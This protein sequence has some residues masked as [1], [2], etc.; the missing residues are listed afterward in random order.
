MKETKEEKATGADYVELLPEEIVI[1]EEINVRPWSTAHESEADQAAIE[2]LKTSIAQE[3]QLQAIRVREVAS[4]GDKP[5]YHLIAGR[6]R[7]NAIF[8]LNAELSAKNK[9]GIR[10]KAIVARDVDDPAAYRQAAMENIIRRDMSPMDIA[11]VIKTVREN[12][13]WEGGKN[14]KSVAKYLGVSPATISQHEKLLTLP[15]EIQAKVHAGELSAQA[16][17]DYKE[18]ADKHGKEAADEVLAD[19]KARQEAE[20]AGKVTETAQGAKG[21]EANVSSGGEEGEIAPTGQGTRKKGKV[22]RAGKT[23]TAIKARHVQSAARQKGLGM[24]PLGKSDIVEF[25]EKKVAA[26]PEVNGYRNGDV[27][28]FVRSLISWFDGKVKDETLLKHFMTVTAKADRGKK[29]KPE[30]KKAE[31]PAAKAAGKTAKAKAKPKK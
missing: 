7:V 5:S 16:G 18:I 25:W 24:K 21:S 15:E 22:A 6:R 27:D 8:G 9:P 3:G 12:M 23:K 20:K 1:D 30:S 26:N 31:K 10:V 29:P 14:T 17:F 2:Q 11:E 28:Y 4:N 19:A 13:G